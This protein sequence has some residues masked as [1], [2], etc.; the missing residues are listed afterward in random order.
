VV[1]RL[2]KIN[3]RLIKYFIGIIA[4]VVFVCFIGSSLFLSKFY[5]KHQYNLLERNA[6]DIYESLKDGVPYQSFDISAIVI[7]D[8]QIYFLGQSKMGIMPFIR[9]VDYN[10]IKQSGKFK[11]PNGENFLYYKY[12]TELGDVV[13]FKSSTESS[14]YL[15]I[16][17]IILLVVFIIS[18][19]LCIPVISYLG[20]K[21]T[22]PI[23]KLQKASKEIAG[24]NFKV[25]M[26]I[27][28][29]DE[30]EELYLSL[31]LAAK[32][33]EKKNSMQRDFIANVSHDFRTPLSIIRNYAEAISDN[34]IDNK[35]KEEYSNI[36]I[37]EVDRLNLMVGDLL[38][39]SKLKE[40]HYMLNSIW[41]D[42]GELL[43][44][45]MDKFLNIATN[46]SVEL[47]LNIS[48]I[49]VLGDYNY[50]SRVLYNFID[51]AI[52]FSESGGKVEIKSTITAEGIKVSVKD[53]GIG[54]RKEMLSEIWDR[55]YKHSQSG[56]MGLG[57]PISSEILRL[58]GFSYGVESVLED[59]SEFFFIIPEN[60]YRLG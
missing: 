58:H 12:Q 14:E 3:K 25:D 4:F 16:I 36:I 2:S 38:Q 51:N 9:N 19:L 10:T 49:E 45:C 27:D 50:L 32:E 5:M 24:G 20:S 53:H 60:L 31:N 33:L 22:R 6:H 11:V 35:T 26:K 8:G 18:I 13:V 39:L 15:N 48:S 56:G 40:G 21:F 23:L 37:S 52:K 55:Y 41:F 42:L 59:G 17:Y 44:N 29:G 47:T 30:I 7:K 34:I 57:L 54:I 1:S 43:K 46:K 28:T